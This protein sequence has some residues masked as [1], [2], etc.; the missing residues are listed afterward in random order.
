M[1]VDKTD[2]TSLNTD[3]WL[4]DLQRDNAK[5][6]TFDPAFDVTP[7]WSPDASQLVFAS[8]RGYGVDLHT[9]TSAGTQE[10]KTIIHDE[11][12]KFPNDWSRDGKYILCNR[13][14]DLWLISV[15][16]MKGTLFL[17]A[18]SVVR[19]GRFSPD[20]RWVAYASNET[21]KWEI[22]VTSFPEA[23]GKWQT[24]SGGGEQP[25]GEATARNC[26]TLLP[27]VRSWRFR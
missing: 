21:G 17:K 14:R 7:I 13:G 25:G 6:L 15:P 23:R 5:R 20:G 3:I 11:F 19:N 16:E 18:V 26:T 8:N 9:K 2:M 22:Y 27:T 1:A 10:E 24:S 4:Y 12:N